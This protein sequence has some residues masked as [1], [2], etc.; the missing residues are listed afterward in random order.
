[1]YNKFSKYSHKEEQTHKD[2]DENLSDEVTISGEEIHSDLLEKQIE[3]EVFR[4]DQGKY[5]HDN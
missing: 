1:M 3:E 2:D 5:V 4:Q